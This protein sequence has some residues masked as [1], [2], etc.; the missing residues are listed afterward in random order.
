MCRVST[1]SESHNSLDGCDWADRNRD[2]NALPATLRVW[3]LYTARLFR[4]ARSIANSSTHGARAPQIC[5]LLGGRGIPDSW[6]RRD[7]L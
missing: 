1:C 5:N 7:R 4:Q 2:A 6:G 3:C